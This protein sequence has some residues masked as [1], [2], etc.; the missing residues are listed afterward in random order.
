MAWLWTGD[1]PLRE[2]MM[3]QFIAT[4]MIIWSYW[5][6]IIELNHVEVVMDVIQV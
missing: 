6:T 3:A 2:S 4:I 1:K 5:A